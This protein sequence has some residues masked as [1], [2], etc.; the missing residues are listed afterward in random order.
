MFEHLGHLV[1]R[2]RRTAIGPLV[3]GNL[4]LGGYR[5]LS[6]REVQLLQDRKKRRQKSKK[7]A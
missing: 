2:V 4:S 3:L 1:M 5:K 7:S 6:T